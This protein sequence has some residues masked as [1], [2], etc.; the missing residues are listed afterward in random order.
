MSKIYVKVKI[1]TLAEEAKII[2]KEENKQKCHILGCKSL[3]KTMRK[4][5]EKNYPISKEDLEIRKLKAQNIHMG[6]KVHRKN[7]VRI[8][9]RATHLAYAFMREKTYISTENK[10][11]ISKE[12]PN[13]KRVAEIVKKYDVRYNYT[14]PGNVMKDIMVWAG[15]KQNENGWWERPVIH[16]MKADNI[17]VKVHNSTV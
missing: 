8:E 2:R 16:Q 6:L 3:L 1:K 14:G 12:L 13:W 5:P 11:K 9:S 4:E 10:N 15:Y 17:D 7:I